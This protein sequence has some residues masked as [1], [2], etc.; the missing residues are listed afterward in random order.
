MKTRKCAWYFRDLSILALFRIEAMTPPDSGIKGFRLRSSPM[1]P[2]NNAGGGRRRR[3]RKY[4][5]KRRKER[6]KNTRAP[7]KFAGESS[8]IAVRQRQISNAFRRREGGRQDQ[9]TEREG[10]R[11][12]LCQLGI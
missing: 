1:S 8:E 12:H 4:F 5:Q 3:R 6:K 9:S 10:F 7:T 2:V 11:E